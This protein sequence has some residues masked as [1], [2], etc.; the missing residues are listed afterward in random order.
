MDKS[1]AEIA[2]W[3]GALAKL[4][5]CAFAGAALASIIALPAKID[6]S[7]AVYLCVESWKL[8]LKPEHCEQYLNGE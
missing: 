5:L 8:G 6:Q 4:A 3:V 2:G 1:I 7:R